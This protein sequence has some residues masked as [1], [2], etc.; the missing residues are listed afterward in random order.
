MNLFLFLQQ[1]GF[2]TA[3][4]KQCFK[5]CLFVFSEF[6]TIIRGEFSLVYFSITRVRKDVLTFKML[7]N[8]L[9]NCILRISKYVNP[10]IIFTILLISFDYFLIVPIFKGFLLFLYNKP[11]TKGGSHVCKC[12]ASFSDLIFPSSTKSV[13]VLNIMPL[14]VSC[15]LFLGWNEP[16]SYSD[17]YKLWI[18]SLKVPKDLA[19]RILCHK[20]R[21]VPHLFTF[22]APQK[23]FIHFWVSL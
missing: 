22:Q 6:V 23:H 10:I 11:S 4:K 14:G 17:V 21:V 3:F 2:T 5:T 15:Y 12:S 8:Y 1:F 20:P 18:D 9:L 16:E 19:G 7:H 13:I